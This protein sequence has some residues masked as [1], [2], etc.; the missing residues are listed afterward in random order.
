MSLT[1]PLCFRFIAIKW[2]FNVA[3]HQPATSSS[4]YNNEPSLWGNHYATDGVV[5]PTGTGIFS[6]HYEQQPWLM[7][8]LNGLQM[9]TFVRVFNRRDSVG[10][11]F[12]D[13]SLKQT[14]YCK[15]FIVNFFLSKENDFMT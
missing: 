6:T 11:L 8:T 7:V 4:V 1:F 5:P 2:T 14:N 9:I 15:K 10:K 12:H 3:L 13:Y